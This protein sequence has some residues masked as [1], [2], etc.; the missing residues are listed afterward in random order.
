MAMM[1]RFLCDS[2]TGGHHVSKDF[3]IAVDGE[4]LQCQQ[5]TSNRH[6]PFAVAILKDGIMVWSR[7]LKNLIIPEKTWSYSMWYAKRQECKFRD[8]KIT[9]EKMKI[10]TPQNF[11]RI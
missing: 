5:E 1:S 3:R 7:S 6:D 11:P 2:V 8:L 4:V 9:H 10:N